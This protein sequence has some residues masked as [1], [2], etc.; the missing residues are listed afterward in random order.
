MR[1]A[2]FM[3]GTF[4]P[5]ETELQGLL[6]KI[7]TGAATPAALKPVAEKIKTLTAQSEKMTEGL[8]GI[9]SNS[10]SKAVRLMASATAGV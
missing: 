10:K 9:S 6:G 8:P 7:K 4:A 1:S 3:K 5:L 2:A